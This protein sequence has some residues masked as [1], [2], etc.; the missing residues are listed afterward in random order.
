MKKKY[1][2]EVDCANCAAKIEE[3]MKKVP[4]VINASVN[5][6]TQKVTIEAAEEEFEAIVQAAYKAAKKVEDEFEMRIA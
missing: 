3:T 5:F 2:C 4:G 1:A 6:L